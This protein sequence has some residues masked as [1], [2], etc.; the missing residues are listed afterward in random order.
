MCMKIDRRVEVSIPEEKCHLCICFQITGWHICLKT[1]LK[2]HQQ[3][4]WEWSY[5]SSPPEGSTDDRKGISR[6][7][8]D[9]GNL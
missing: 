3:G 7:E 2:S 4:C 5:L 1:L 9:R 6:V 8:E